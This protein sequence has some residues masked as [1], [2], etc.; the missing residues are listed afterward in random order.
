M[1]FI[2]GV[3]IVVCIY[4]AS[5]YNKL[6]GMMQN[7]K[8][9]YSNIQANL[10]K[11]QNLQEQIIDMAKEYANKEQITQ[12]E[13][14]KSNPQV[15]NAL[16]QSFPELKSNENF[17]HLSNQIQSLEDQINQKREKYNSDVNV[18]NSYR[19]SIP[20][21]FIAQKFKFNIVDYFDISDNDF[22]SASIKFQRDDTVALNEMITSASKKISDKTVNAKNLIN[23]KISE[24][25]EKKE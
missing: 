9:S 20:A 21:V 15:A 8:E 19:N 3:I 12:I 10:Q 6:S 24:I 14:A 7:I 18:Y 1:Y 22:T 16:S 4:L 23:D 25:K 11:R 5:I 13:I 17:L 2:L